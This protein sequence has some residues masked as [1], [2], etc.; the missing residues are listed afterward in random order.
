MAATLN[1]VA[2]TDDPTLKQMNRLV[3]KAQ[4]DRSHHQSNLRLLYQHTMPWRHTFDQQGHSP[5][6]TEIFDETAGLVLEDFAAEMLN[7]FTPQ[8]NNWV[9]IEPVKTLDRGDRNVISSELKKYQ[10]V[11]FNSMAR[12]NLYMAL[13]EAYM[14]LGPGTMALLITDIGSTL[15]FHCEAIP[16]TE[17]LITRGP[18][19]YVD[20]VFRK[21]RYARSEIQRLWPDAKM[22]L[23]GQMPTPGND[24]EYDVI[25]GCW[26]D[27]SD[28]GDEKYIY[29]V[30]ANGKLI[31]DKTYKGEG[32]CP[33]IVARWNTDSTTAWGFG[34]SYRTLPAM[35]TRNHVRFTA[36]KN[37]DKHVDPPMSYVDDG[38]ANFDSGIEPG[39]YF[40][41]APDSDAPSPLETKTRFD[42]QVFEMDE[43]ASTIR[44]A[45]YQDRPEQQGKTPPTATQ[46]ADEAAERARRMGTPA[47]RLVHELQ[48][49]LFKRFAYLE[50]QRGTLPKVI[51]QGEEV[52]LQPISPLLRAQEQEEVVRNDKFAELISARFGPQIAMVV[53]DIVKYAG[54]QGRLL[55]IKTELIRNESDIANAIKQL[56]PVLQSATAGRP[57]EIIPPQLGAIT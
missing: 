31:Y 9:S 34:P 6:Q 39:K 15:P 3:T 24:P 51:L 20:G 49:P 2:S 40:P 5:D 14:D 1:V 55:G 35:R 7:T 21:K 56:M 37:F 29:G 23:L 57:G 10:D 32:S 18:Y 11:V 17:L 38:V 30:Q 45:H 4:Q 26:R 33:F 25:D 47:T 50:R 16:A 43:L 52:S 44:R 54:E 28:R 53:I 22:N 36:L 12:S 13:Q 8:K 46:W 19:G 42:V 41:R 48:Y 27:W